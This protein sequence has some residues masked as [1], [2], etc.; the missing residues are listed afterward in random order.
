MKIMTRCTENH[1][2]LSTFDAL[3][4]RKTMTTLIYH[5]YQAEPRPRAEGGDY[6]A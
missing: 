6:A 1:D 5:T 2:G 4:V 3:T